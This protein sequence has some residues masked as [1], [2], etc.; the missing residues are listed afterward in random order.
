MGIDG[1]KFQRQYREH[2]SNFNTWDQ[3]EHAQ[4]FLFYPKNIGAHL[5]LDETCISNGELYTILTNKAKKGKK[6]SIVAMIK[7]VDAKTIVPLITAHI[8]DRR[9][10]M[11]K[12]ITLDMASS[13][14]EI[15]RSCFKRASL[16]IDRFHVQKL[17][18]DA[19]QSVRVKYR[20]EAIEEENEAFIKAKKEGIRYKQELLSNGDTLKQLLARSRY[21]LYKNNFKWSENQK[22]EPISYLRNF[23]R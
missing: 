10:N 14:N 13:M 2:L 22:K 18:Y 6:G 21:L 7:G 9:R 23:L 5:S 11:V 19:V 17:T 8:S 12:E 1:K 16:V 20:W 3:K 15:A 4:D